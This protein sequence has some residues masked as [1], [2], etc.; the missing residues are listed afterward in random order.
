MCLVSSGAPLIIPNP[1]VVSL[2]HSRYLYSRLPDPSRAK[3]TLF[4][5][6]SL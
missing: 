4:S 2:T 3:W 5:G 1:T 6:G